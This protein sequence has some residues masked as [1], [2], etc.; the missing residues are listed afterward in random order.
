MVEVFPIPMANAGKADPLGGH[1]VDA[2]CLIG[3]LR[4]VARKVALPEIIR[5]NDHDVRRFRGIGGC[6]KAAT[7]KSTAAR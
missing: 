5:V 2:G 7:A 3:R 6:R 1:A 4:V